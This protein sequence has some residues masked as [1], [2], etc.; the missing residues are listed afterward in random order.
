MSLCGDSV[1][2]R[3]VQ[4]VALEEIRGGKG[5]WS[6]AAWGHQVEGGLSS[7]MGLDQRREAVEGGAHTGLH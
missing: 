4:R 6:K 7:M 2:D 5:E 1:S 3:S